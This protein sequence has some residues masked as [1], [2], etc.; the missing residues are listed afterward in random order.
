M[1]AES[2]TISFLEQ[3]LRLELKKP[4]PDV[5]KLR[6]DCQ[7]RTMRHTGGFTVSRR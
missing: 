1:G 6:W 7:A 4:D 5:A 3:L 2:C